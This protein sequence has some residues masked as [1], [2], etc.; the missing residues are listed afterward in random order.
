[1]KGRPKT[2]KMKRTILYL[3]AAALLSAGCAK[4]PSVGLNDAAKRYF[5]SWMSVAYPDAV[6]EEPGYYV[7][8]DIPGNGMLAGDAD[9][10]PYVR[11]DYVIR[12]QD[13][14]I[15]DTSYE[16]LAQQVG[17]YDSADYYGP[18]IW[19]RGSGNMQA[20]LDEALKTM[21]TGGY[22][23]FVM[24]G[25][26]ATT[27]RFDTEAEYLANVSGSV[28]VYDVKLLELITD[29][30]KWETDSVGRY[31]SKT[32]P[33]KTVQDSLKYGFYYFCTGEPSSTRE[34]PA[35]TTIYINYVGRLLNGQV[36]DTN[37]KDS[38]KFYGLYS[39]SA[40]YSPSTITWHSSEGTY[41]DIKMGS[42]TVIDGFS[43]ALSKMHPHEKGTA[44]FYSG[45]GYGSSGSGSTIPAYGPLRFDIEIVDKP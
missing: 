7:L 4:T 21:R 10:T 6:R 40:T 38:A 17:T 35:D 42:S 24:P 31:V 29:V 25:W 5:D 13:G 23:S 41:K 32:F 36:F 44:V 15:N 45:L 8:E 39:A 43:Y 3:C 11:V 26:L 18:V 28:T 1:M 20:G 30:K 19:L 34:F 12:S 22:R 16:Q 14:T 9:N 37:V 27:S 33:G 2:S